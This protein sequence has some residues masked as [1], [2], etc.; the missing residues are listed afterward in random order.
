MAREPQNPTAQMLGIEF[1]ITETKLRRKGDIN[2][3]DS[4]QTTGSYDSSNHNHCHVTQ[5]RGHPTTDARENVSGRG[6]QDISSRNTPDWKALLTPTPDTNKQSTRNGIS[7]SS[8]GREG[9]LVPSCLYLR[10]VGPRNLGSS[11]NPFDHHTPGAWVTLNVKGKTG[12]THCSKFPRRIPIHKEF[13]AN[14]IPDNSLCLRFTKSVHLWMEG[15]NLKHDSTGYATISYP[16]VKCR[17]L[18]PNT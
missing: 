10:T 17:A 14:S 3:E 16:I 6:S 12:A 1:G 11:Y 9:S 18:P 4:S 7:L 13:M 2:L 5:T 8:K 15:S